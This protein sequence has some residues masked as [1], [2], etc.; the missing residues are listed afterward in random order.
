MVGMTRMT[1]VV[2]CALVAVGCGATQ[3]TTTVAAEETFDLGSPGAEHYSAALEAALDGYEVDVLDA[4]AEW[5]PSYTEAYASSVS[6]VRPAFEGRVAEALA[7]RQL[8]AAGLAAFARSHP[9]FVA[10]QNQLYRERMS[11][12]R[13]AA[14]AIMGRIDADHPSLQPVVD[15][16]IDTPVG[17]ASR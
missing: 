12:L 3:A 4:V 1:W 11:R 5:Y 15:P 6:F 8:S 17:F 16:P 2:A 13:R 9:E 10:T 14:Y 7:A